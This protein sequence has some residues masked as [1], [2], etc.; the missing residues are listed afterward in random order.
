ME[1]TKYK[2]YTDDWRANHNRTGL[3]GLVKLAYSIVVCGCLVHFP[4]FVQQRWQS[5]RNRGA[6]A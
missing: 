2:E 5:P 1:P 4:Q 6:R 3:P